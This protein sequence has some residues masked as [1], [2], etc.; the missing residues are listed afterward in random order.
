MR[1]D[2]LDLL[3]AC[4]GRGAVFK[5]Q[6]D[7]ADVRSGDVELAEHRH[8][9]ADALLLIEVPVIALRQIERVRLHD[10]PARKE[11]VALVALLIARVHKLD[12]LE[13]V[14][15][16]IPEPLGK[17]AGRV[18]VAA[19]LRAV[20]ELVSKQDIGILQRFAGSE[21][22]RNLRD[23]VPVLHVE[24]RSADRFRRFALLNGQKTGLRTVKLRNT[25]HDAELTVRRNVVGQTH[26]KG[27]RD[28]FHLHIIL[29][30][31]K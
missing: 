26:A 22:V 17:R 2:R 15:I 5:V 30:Y 20:V 29:L 10:R 12:E 31:N 9:R 18:D 14:G 13:R 8:A 7:R 19:A 28:R 27:I 16:L 1:E 6:T 23:P 11:R 3:C 21:K 24:H 4:L 25:A